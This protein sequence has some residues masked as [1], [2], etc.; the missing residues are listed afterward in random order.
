MARPTDTF[1]WGDVS[2]TLVVP[3]NGKKDVG[4]AA[5]EKPPAQTMTYLQNGAGQW[6]AWLNTVL[7]DAKLHMLW[8]AGYTGVGTWTPGV[9]GTGA[10]YVAASASSDQYGFS[11]PLFEGSKLK[12]VKFYYKRASGT[13]RFSVYK[14]DFTGT[15]S[16]SEILF[17]QVSSGTTETTET[18]N[19][20][21]DTVSATE[22]FSCGVLAGGAGD[23]VYGV[24]V[25]YD[26][27]S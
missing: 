13:L 18:V 2:G 11:I 6:F 12:Q 9:N 27:F 20:T 14:M 1:R 26:L 21:D 4:W 25:Q 10:T 3:S 15:W 23:R 17:T 16:G 19:I 24:E 5:G 22:F 8:D 7:V